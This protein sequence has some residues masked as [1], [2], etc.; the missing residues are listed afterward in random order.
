MQ[1]ASTL[2]GHLLTLTENLHLKKIVSSL[3]LRP[4]F[5]KITNKFGYLTGKG[6]DF[7]K[8][9]RIYYLKACLLDTEI[10]KVK[11]LVFFICRCKSLLKK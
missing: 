2:P 9:P 3:L 4:P 7:Q 6:N 10:L 5:S 8:I 1:Q 11:I